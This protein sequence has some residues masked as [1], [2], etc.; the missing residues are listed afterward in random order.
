ME[1]IDWREAFMKSETERGTLAARVQEL[2][3]ENLRLRA[4]N[5]SILLANQML[6][7]RDKNFNEELNRM[8]AIL[9]GAYL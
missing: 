1:K 7:E 2:E 8:Q 6:I 5:E 9:D 3:H 4:E